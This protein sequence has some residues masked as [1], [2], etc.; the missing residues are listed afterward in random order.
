M[1]LHFKKVAIF[2]NLIC[3]L[4]MI[5]FILMV[6]KV[7]VDILVR[8]SSFEKCLSFPLWMIVVE[9]Q[10]QYKVRATSAKSLQ[11]SRMNSL[12][13]KCLS[14][15]TLRSVIYFMRILCC[16]TMNFNLLL[17]IFILLIC[18]NLLS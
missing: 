10:D 8:Y 16:K 7:E 17:T 2:H 15:F 4:I 1:G 3:C 18:F 6:F 12:S 14:I 5:P 9:L 13:L 11:Q